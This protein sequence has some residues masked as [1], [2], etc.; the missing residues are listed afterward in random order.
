[1]Y[2]CI[3]TR[4]TAVALCGMRRHAKVLFAQI[5]YFPTARTKIGATTGIRQ[6]EHFSS[7]SSNDLPHTA[8]PPGNVPF[9]LGY[10]TGILSQKPSHILQ[11][12]LA[13]RNGQP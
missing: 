5:G 12:T 11:L 1:M 3:T 13:S 8:L 9:A 4:L 2:S 6:D 10:P 7:A